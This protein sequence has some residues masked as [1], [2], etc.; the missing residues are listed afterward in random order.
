[1]PLPREAG[2]QARAVVA[3]LLAILWLALVCP[4]V[5]AA[6][7]A[8]EQATESEIQRALA[9]VK[10][11][12]NLAT[13]G[14]RRVPTFGDGK[15]PEREPRAPTAAW[16]RDLFEWVGQTSRALLWVL[17]AIF[18]T[19]LLVML[20]RLLRNPSL[21]RSAA[22]TATPTHVRDLDIRPES[23]PEDIG[24]AA[25]RL[26]DQH[27]QRAALAL[28]YRGLLSRL[29]HA[30]GLQIR[31]STTEAGCIELAQ[32]HLQ[33]EPADY[34]VRLVRGWQRAVYG[35]MHPEDGEF[36]ALCTDFDAMLSP[37]SMHQAAA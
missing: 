7:A 37:G 4:D 5:L 18:G 31:Q 20:V 3:Q 25:L 19:L 1:M 2:M 30:H 10:D 28:L 36:R 15:R 16:L 12:P 33:A 34:V 32:L 21:R 29:V 8:G 27:E 22:A 26:W 24:A 13:E 11:D 9:V 14:K 17:G 6:T 23:L 35:G